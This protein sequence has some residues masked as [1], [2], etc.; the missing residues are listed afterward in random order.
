MEWSVKVEYRLALVS[1]AH[2]TSGALDF[3]MNGIIE[4]LKSI[5]S[6]HFGR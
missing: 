5:A 6:V 4:W 2:F 3:S 1:D